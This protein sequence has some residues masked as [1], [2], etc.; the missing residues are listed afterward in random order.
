LP[1]TYTCNCIVGYAKNSDGKCDP[2]PCPVSNWTATPRDPSIPVTS[3]T[4]DLPLF[5]AA[6]IKVNPS[7]NMSQVPGSD[8]N[9]CMLTSIKTRSINHT[10]WNGSPK[11]AADALALVDEHYCGYP[12]TNDRIYNGMQ[13]I[14]YV[15]EEL[16]T[17]EWLDGAI[18]AALG[19]N[20]S[21][22]TEMPIDVKGDAWAM[23]Y[24]RVIFATCT[25]ATMGQ[26]ADVIYSVVSDIL[27]LFADKG[28]ITVA[29]E[30]VNKYPCAIRVTVDDLIPALT[31]CTEVDNTTKTEDF[32]DG[33]SS[34]E[35]AAITVGGVIV[36]AVA[37]IG[38]SAVL[39]PA[40]V[41]DDAAAYVAL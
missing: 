11:C 20:V 27:P 28:R 5:V 8:C 2:L 33:L 9:A 24:F 19:N 17:Q 16:T 4:L 39:A 18:R 35:I 14:D 41:P 34:G 29:R 3:M 37:G 12:C 30:N 7:V 13:A 21:L 36:T 32:G 40:A 26:A 31:D 10:A 1:G 25:D 23:N 38:A 6:M 15:V 22:F